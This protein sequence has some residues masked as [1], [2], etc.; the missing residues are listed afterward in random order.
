MTEKEN[1]VMRCVICGGLLLDDGICRDHELHWKHMSPEEIKGALEK[2][3]SHLA[4]LVDKVEC[5][6]VELQDKEDKDD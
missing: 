5:M 3:Q 1:T 2:L 4:A 6:S